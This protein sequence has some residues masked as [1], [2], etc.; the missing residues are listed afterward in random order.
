MLIHS[1][2][3]QSL[4]LEIEMAEEYFTLLRATLTIQCGIDLCGA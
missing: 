2:P 3:D 4:H 1:R